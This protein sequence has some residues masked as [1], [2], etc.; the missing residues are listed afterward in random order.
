MR[1]VVT[2]S[3][4]DVGR[5]VVDYLRRQ[6]VTV[7]GVDLIGRGNLDDYIS[8]DL[9]DAGQAFDVLQDADAVIHLG[10]IADPHVFPAAHTFLTNTSIT[11]NVLNA[12]AKLGIRRVVVASSIQI[13]HPAFPHQRIAYRYLPFDEDH[14]PDPHDEYGLS[15]WIG[16]ACADQFAHHWGMTIVS[17][18][19]TWSV[20]PERMSLFPI[21]M[22][23]ALP[24]PDPRAR[25]WMPTPF[26]VDARD[27]AR[28]AY[29][30]ATVDLPAATHIPLIITARDSTTDITSDE[31]ARRFFPQ[32]ERH[33]G[34]KGFNSICSGARAEQV[35]GFVPEYTWRGKS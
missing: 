29:L 31:I 11:Y 7:L 23:D 16:E 9:T 12:A 5:F 21:H 27:C 25:V 35:L 30:A 28:A 33:A 4:G 26:Y 17:L 6:D 14:A 13:H 22:P 19:I 2:G 24:E 3:K 10:A 18:R 20:S 1:I 8:A 34:L 32:A 15:K